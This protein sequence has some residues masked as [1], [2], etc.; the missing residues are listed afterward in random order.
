MCIFRLLAVVL[1]S[2]PM[3]PERSDAR[4]KVQALKEAGRYQEAQRVATDALAAS[5]PSTPESFIA[6]SDLLNELGDTFLFEGAYE[7]ADGMFK[8]ALDALERSGKPDPIRHARLL[9]NRGVSLLYRNAVEES[10]PLLEQ[11]FELRRKK[12][13]SNHWA[14]AESID[15][16][17][18]ARFKKGDLQRSEEARREAVRIYRLSTP[19]KNTDLGVA[20]TNLAE[21]CR[22]ERKFDDAR[23]FFAE[24]AMI[25]KTLG[26][27]HPRYLAVLSNIS[28]LDFDEGRV[29]DALAI[30][31]EVARARER[32]LGPNHPDTIQSI[33]NC[34][35]A[36]HRLGRHA[37]ALRLEKKANIARKEGPAPSVRSLASPSP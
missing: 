13:G 20:L 14:V 23:Q 29:S 17:G 18:L 31:Q 24:A 12:L 34:A 4:A 6:H 9:H 16:I 3:P 35:I 1:M 36:L 8:K 28:A 25:L 33:E 10:L 30:E 32:V 27:A 21:T 5:A 2:Q 7:A 15:A 22:A 26:A 37:E 11:A 19:E